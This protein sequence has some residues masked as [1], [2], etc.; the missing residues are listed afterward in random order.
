MYCS[1]GRGL[2]TTLSKL[3]KKITLIHAKGLLLC[4]ALKLSVFFF[5]EDVLSL[6]ENISG[7][8]ENIRSNVE[9]SDSFA[10]C[11]TDDLLVQYV[12]KFR[13]VY[14]ERGNDKNGSTFLV[15]YT[16]EKENRYREKWLS[17]VETR[18]DRA[19]QSYIAFMQGP[20]TFRILQVF[21]NRFGLQWSYWMPSFPIE[22]LIEEIKRFGPHLFGGQ[23]GRGLLSTSLAPSYLQDKVGCSLYRCTPVAASSNL[24]NHVIVVVGA[25]K[26]RCLEK[27]VYFIDPND[28]SDPTLPRIVYTMDYNWFSRNVVPIGMDAAHENAPL[29]ACHFMDSRL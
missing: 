26:I 6:V 21:M 17:Q 22:H 29:Y 24:P 23:L 20:S 11:V 13:R 19:L 28:V 10:A 7:L 18:E 9:G 27:T 1:L 2:V 15:E 12:R 4:N 8:R 16:K 3:R 5:T 25:Q 14:E